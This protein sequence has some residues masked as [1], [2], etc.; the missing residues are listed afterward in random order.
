[1][2]ALVTG[3]AGFIGSHLTES[4]L[5][6]EHEVIGVD[7]FNDNNAWPDKIRNLTVARS[8]DAF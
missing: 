1:V 4:L 8:Y 7:C 3:S 5:R 6:D 2:R